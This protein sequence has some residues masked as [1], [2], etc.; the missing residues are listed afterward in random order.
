MRIS[1][2]P[3]LFVGLYRLF[4]SFSFGYELNDDSSYISPVSNYTY[5]KHVNFFLS[6][7]YSS[8]SLSE[9]DSVRDWMPFTHWLNAIQSLTHCTPVQKVSE[10]GWEKWQDKKGKRWKLHIKR[11]RLIHF[12]TE[13]KLS[14]QLSSIRAFGKSNNQKSAFF[15]IHMDCPLTGWM[16]S[17]DSACR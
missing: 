12:Y 16:N 14:R 4:D 6:R 3:K 2:F 10:G 7:S 15:V 9:P 1:P 11:H 17:M 8:D 13:K 5:K